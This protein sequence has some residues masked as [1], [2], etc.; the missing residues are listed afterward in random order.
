MDR[1]VTP[2]DIQGTLQTLPLRFLGEYS[3]RDMS[4][5]RAREIL[6]AIILELLESQDP[7]PVL[8][9]QSKRSLLSEDVEV[10]VVGVT[11]FV[12]RHPPSGRALAGVNIVDQHIHTHTN[13]HKNTP[14]RDTIASPQQQ[15]TQ[16]EMRE[17]FGRGLHSRYQTTQ[18]HSHRRRSFE[19]SIARIGNPR[20]ADDEMICWQCLKN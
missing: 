19:A 3:A 9:A 8:R 4:P 20:A 11:V 2:E 10:C 15:L 7:V 16:H 14:R 6:G 13:T 17:F 18:L 12:L 1:Q 5:V